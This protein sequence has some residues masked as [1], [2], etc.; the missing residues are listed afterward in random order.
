MSQNS[1]NH[2]RRVEMEARRAAER[3][4]RFH[5]MRSAMVEA[6]AKAAVAQARLQK[7]ASAAAQAE[8][9]AEI[10][11]GKAAREAVGPAFLRRFKDI[12]SQLRAVAETKARAQFREELAAK[13][14]EEAANRAEAE[15]AKA[16]EAARLA[17]ARQ[18]AGKPT[19]SQCVLI[20]RPTVA[21]RP[22][23]RPAPKRSADRSSKPATVRPAAKLVVAEPAGVLLPGRRI[24]IPPMRRSFTVTGEMAGSMLYPRYPASQAACAV[25]A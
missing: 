4:Y 21:Q 3:K 17:A 10:A 2:L 25:A 16:E 24:V 20:S 22:T 7:T 23:P 18:S 13:K 8:F 11:A 9:A 5:P 14:A 12:N 15:K 6:Q 19:H 1:S